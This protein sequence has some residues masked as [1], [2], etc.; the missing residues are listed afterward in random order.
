MLLKNEK[1]QAGLRKQVILVDEAGLVSSGD[2]RGI[3]DIAKKQQSRVILVGDYRQH[4][5]IEAGDAFRLIESEAGVRYAEL[6]EIRRQTEPG[7]K[8]AVE[9]IAE[10]TGKAAQ[11]GFDFLQ[12]KGWIVE[13]QGE[14]RHAMLA[15]AT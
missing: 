15:K 3:F 1:L 14:E 2:M 8:K 7:Y 6:K 4:S 5:S 9:A 12:K 10:G 13:A 11:K